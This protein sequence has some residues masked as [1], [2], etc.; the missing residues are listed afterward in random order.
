VSNTATHFLG[1]DEGTT[2]VRAVLIDPSGTI[3]AQA[4]AGIPVVYPQ[5]G[6]VEHHGETLWQTTR[7]VIER[8]LSSAGLEAADV[9]AIGITNQRA[10]AVA[11]DQGGHPV[12]PVIGW[13][14]QRT[15]ARCMELLE[16]GHFVLSNTAAS[17]YEWLLQNHAKGRR[18]IRLGTIDAYLAC[19][20][21]AGEVFASDHSNYS[22]SGVY[23]I[24]AGA[25]DTKTAA[26]LGIEPHNLPALVDTSGVIGET[27][28]TAFGARVPIAALAGDQ[29]AAMYSQAAHAKGSIELQL[30]TSGMVKRNEGPTLGEF[31]AGS[32]PLVLWALDGERTFCVESPVLTAGA[33]AGWLHEGLGIISDVTELE[34]LARSVSDSDGVWVVPAFAGLG[35]PHLEL[36][37]RG[38]IGG[39]S[40]GS[41]H[42]HIARAMLEGIAARCGEAALA[43]AEGPLAR[44]RV[45]GGA[46][47]NGLLLQMLA[48]VTGAVVERPRVLDR[49]GLGAALLAGRALGQV[50]DQ[51]VAA[52]WEGYR[53]FEPAISADERGAH[54][55]VWSRRIALVREAVG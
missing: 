43:L 30:G 22:V 41:T 28:R 54:R 17:K 15:T 29:H 40:R 26:V 31:P 12:G 55:E 6:W 36:A 33:A 1:I 47:K 2:G 44:L 14:D 16:E 53:S 46:A 24:F 49:A 8:A 32:Y 21:S 3:H 13:Q 19:R 5:P 11:F 37:A 20:L 34:S 51:Q 10:S 27:D 45:A 42:A 25:V 35:G 9:A 48:D 4:Y 39:L 50:T 7:A 18:D 38:M 23:D 52:S